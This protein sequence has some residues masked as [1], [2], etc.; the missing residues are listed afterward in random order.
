MHY[1]YIRTYVYPYVYLYT[2][3][4]GRLQPAAGVRPICQNICKHTNNNTHTNNIHNNNNIT[5]SITTIT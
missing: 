2:Y 1:I 3:P 4:G 5:I